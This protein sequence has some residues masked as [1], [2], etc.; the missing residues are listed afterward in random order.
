MDHENLKYFQELHKLNGRQARQ[1]LKLQDYNF[2]LC[3]ISGEMNT[4]ADVLSRK[5]QVDTKEDNKNVLMLKEEIWTKRQITG[6]V[7]LIWKNQVV[8]ETT[9][10]EKI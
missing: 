7:T 1:Y 6:E 2:T 4:K 5:D 10:L 8:E 3:H 9:L